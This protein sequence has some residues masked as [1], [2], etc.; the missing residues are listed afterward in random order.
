MNT[1]NAMD[2]WSGI[3]SH[4]SLNRMFSATVLAQISLAAKWGD[5]QEGLFRVRFGG[6][7]IFAMNFSLTWQFLAGPVPML[8]EFALNSSIAAG[9]NAA[10]STTSFARSSMTS[11]ARAVSSSLTVLRTPFT[12]RS[13]REAIV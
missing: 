12:R 5:K 9:L 13:S 10:A 2:K 8:F 7:I 6:Q 3:G 11:I 1:L 4:V